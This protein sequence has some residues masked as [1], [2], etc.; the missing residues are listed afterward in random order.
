M[1]LREDI[2]CA[3]TKQRIRG[4]PDII[5]LILGNDQSEFFLQ[6]LDSWDELDKVA[7]KSKKTIIE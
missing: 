2:D 6:C 1:K 3:V 5:A 7:Q 4:L